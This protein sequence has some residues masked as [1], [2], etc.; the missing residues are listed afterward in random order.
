MKQA[1][2]SIVTISLSA[3]MDFLL[4]P[5]LCPLAVYEENSPILD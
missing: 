2:I 1:V 4:V 5:V 3:E